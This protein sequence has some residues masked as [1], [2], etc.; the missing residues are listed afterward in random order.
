MLL[1]N[2]ETLFKLKL[3]DLQKQKEGLLN[4]PDL[5]PELLENALQELD[6]AIEKLQMEHAA[7]KS[8]LASKLSV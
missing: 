1:K 3:E 6:Q 5:S 8:T 2:E 7:V 4:N